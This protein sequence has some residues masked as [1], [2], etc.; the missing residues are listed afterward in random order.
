MSSGDAK[1]GTVSRRPTLD[2][3]RPLQRFA[4]EAGVPLVDAR[5]AVRRR[6]AEGV[7]E[8]ELFWDGTHPKASGHAI[9][10]ATLA[11]VVREELRRAGAGP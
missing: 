2:H 9:I 3:D 4:A 10:A 5:A 11:P 1:R 7:A 6:L 8:D